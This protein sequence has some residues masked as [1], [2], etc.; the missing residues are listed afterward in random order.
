MLPV[1]QFAGGHPRAGAL[2]Y[3]FRVVACAE[4]LEFQNGQKKTP[5]IERD[6]LAFFADNTFWLSLA[7]FRHR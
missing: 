6:L 5:S 1:Y 2:P 7:D 3:I 4:E